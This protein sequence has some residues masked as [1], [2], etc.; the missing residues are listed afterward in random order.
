MEKE[1][2]KDV[3][4]WSGKYQISSLGRLKSFGGKY[5]KK[6]PE[7]YLTEGTI[8]CLGYRVLTLRVPGKRWMQ[9]AHRL[10]A[11]HF[12][13]KKDGLNFVNHKDGN[14]LN[15]HYLN[16]EWVTAGDN[17]RHAVATG[18][19]NLKGER[20]PHAKLTI[21]KVMKMRD[22]RKQGLTHQEIAN[23]FGVDRRQAGDVINGVNWGWLRYGL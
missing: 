6:H 13:E 8:D 12:C 17:I 5:K 19:L 21:E 10:V 3:N 15:N 22:L 23:M 14:K 4:G 2:W 11:E 20:H 1:E 16:L 9:R 7:G 18:L